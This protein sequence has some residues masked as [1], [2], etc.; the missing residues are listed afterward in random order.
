MPTALPLRLPP[1][2]PRT[3]FHSTL[4]GCIASEQQTHH[5]LVTCAPFWGA[6]GQ[7]CHGTAPVWQWLT[8][9]IGSALRHHLQQRHRQYEC[10]TC[11]GL[12]RMRPNINVS[13]GKEIQE[14]LWSELATLSPG[15]LI[16]YK[17]CLHAEL[18]RHNNLHSTSRYSTDT[19]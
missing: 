6:R 3:P 15:V 19:E 16:I 11:I 17:P 5:S 14:W 12:K 8:V 1:S 13:W 7:H 4:K 10:T 9:S 2:H 18:N